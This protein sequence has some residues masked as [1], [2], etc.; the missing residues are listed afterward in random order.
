V[1]F[2]RLPDMVEETNHQ[3]GRTMTKFELVED[4]RLAPRAC[5]VDENDGAGGDGRAEFKSPK[6]LSSMAKY[7]QDAYLVSFDI[8]MEDLIDLPANAF[9][10]A[11]R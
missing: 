4:D 9:S 2:Q 1:N 5:I 3:G 7:M 8:M 11:F 6:E 10:L